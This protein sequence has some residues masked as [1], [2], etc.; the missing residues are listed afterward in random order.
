MKPVWLVVHKV[1]L[2]V[3]KDPK[4]ELKVVTTTSEKLLGDIGQLFNEGASTVHEWNSEPDLQ[5]LNK[6]IET[7]SLVTE[8]EWIRMHWRKP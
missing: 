6:S 8:S 4:H 1:T 7:R 3:G 2:A 5:A